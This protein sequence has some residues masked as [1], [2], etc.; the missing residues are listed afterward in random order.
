[1]ER[2][3]N[4]NNDEKLNSVYT[5]LVAFPSQYIY[6]TMQIMEVKDDAKNW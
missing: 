2:Y 6:T 1:M 4:D 3:N 5:L